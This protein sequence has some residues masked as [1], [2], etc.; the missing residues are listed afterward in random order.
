MHH[1]GSGGPVNLQV[2]GAFHGA[3]SS[4]FLSQDFMGAFNA[5]VNS[6]HTAVASRLPV[7]H[8]LLISGRNAQ[9]IMAHGDTLFLKIRVEFTIVCDSGFS[10]YIAL[11]A[12]GGLA[13]LIA[14]AGCTLNL[15]PLTI[16]GGGK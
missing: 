9:E 5:S 10:V 11:T 3:V 6:G 7:A 8:G 4:C 1:L 13:A 2:L 12:S 15:H 14:L 16:L